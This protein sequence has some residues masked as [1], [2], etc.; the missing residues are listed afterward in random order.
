MH[1]E[2]GE[3]EIITVWVNDLLLFTSSTQSCERIKKDLCSEWEITD[4][5]EPAKIIGIEIMKS[6]STITILQNQYMLNILKR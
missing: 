5:G 6:K 4:L 1:G 2:K 3:Y